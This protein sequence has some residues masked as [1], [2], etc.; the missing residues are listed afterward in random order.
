LAAVAAC[1]Q[2]EWGLPPETRSKF[3]RALEW[4]DAP[5]PDLAQ[6]PLQ[7][8]PGLEADDAM[9][10]AAR[11]T[12]VFHFQRMVAHELGTR[13]GQD[14][15]E[16]HDMR[17]ATRRMRAA[18]RVFGDYVDPLVMRPFRQALRRTGRALGAVRD[19]DVFREKA[20]RYLDAL[21]ADRQAEL[22]PLLA[23]WQA[24]RDAARERML[25][26]LDSP[27]Y[28]R[29]KEQFGEFLR[30]PGAGALPS[31]GAAGEPLPHRVRYVVPVALY[32]GLSAV[33]AFEPA[34]REPDV[35]LAR[36]HQLRIA[37]K[38]LRYTLEFFQPVLGSKSKPLINQV[39]R[40]Q[41]HL[42]DL[43]DAV[44]A[45]DVLRNFLAWGTWVR[46]EDETPPPSTGPIVAPGVDA[47]LAFRQAEIQQL[48][49][50]FPPVWKPIRNS[51]FGRQLA[52]LVAEL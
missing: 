36:Y 16:L 43:Q 17:V 34:L 29:F 21:P 26:W 6:L 23:V 46:P 3:E 2:D 39:K 32:R 9:A 47:Y 13:Q 35:P 8:K 41:D 10:E 45:C 37:F 19:L 49:A 27:R 31:V 48:V 1:L 52:A 38:G 40:L 4:L 14:I 24:Q 28:A 33:R 7:A 25:A 12:L 15:E 18:L 30:T 44:V 5:A 20:Q 11:K 51:D 50:T 22:D 42:G